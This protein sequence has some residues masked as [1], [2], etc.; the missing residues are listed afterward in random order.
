MSATFVS[1][2]CIG[3]CAHRRNLALWT[4]QGWIAMFYIAAGYAKLTEPQ[5]LL[6]LLLEWPAHVPPALV[7]GLGIAE[8]VLATMLLAPLVSWRLGRPLLLVAAFGLGVLESVMTLVHLS[9]LHWGHATI[10]LILL[11][12]TLTVFRSRAREAR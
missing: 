3:L 8:T 9:D 7:Q 6:I 11:A 12:M 4:L 5:E 2:P 10:N 1:P